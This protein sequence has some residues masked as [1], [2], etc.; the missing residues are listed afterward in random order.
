[1]NKAEAKEKAKEKNDNLIRYN[2]PFCPI[3]KEECTNKCVC[4]SKF[5]TYTIGPDAYAVGGG[6]CTCYALVGGEV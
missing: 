1:M 5:Y 6:Y 4:W 2:Q 3:I